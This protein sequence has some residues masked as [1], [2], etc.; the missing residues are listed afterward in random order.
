[1]TTEVKL[2]EKF[3]LIAN[4]STSITCY[5]QGQSR[6][7]YYNMSLNLNNNGSRNSCYA[8]SSGGVFKR[9][10]I[11]PRVSVRLVVLGL[12]GMT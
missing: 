11:H 10:S 7:V 1:M 6:S 12:D 4:S 5:L 9:H 8:S 2:I 3:P